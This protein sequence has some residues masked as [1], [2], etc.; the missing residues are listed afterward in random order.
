MRHGRYIVTNVTKNCPEMDA[1]DAW[2]KIQKLL[3]VD[4]DQI[5]RSCKNKKT[6]EELL[7]KNFN[8]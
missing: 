8:Y 3:N 2:I 7:K 6:L 5:I 1:W 4:K